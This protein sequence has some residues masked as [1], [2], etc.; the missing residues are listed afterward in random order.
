MGIIRKFT[1][2][3][4]LIAKN[5]IHVIIFGA[6]KTNSIRDLNPKLAKHGSIYW[7]ALGGGNV[8]YIG[9]YL[10][11]IAELEGLVRFVKKA[12]DMPEP[13]VGLTTSPVPAHLWQMKID[14]SLCDLNYKIISSLKDDS[15]KPTSVVAEELGVSTKTVRRR[16]N[17]MA[18]NFLI[19]SPSTGTLM[20]ETI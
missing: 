13:T 19:V 7:L 10:K 4:S 18:K 8:L 6:S 2:K 9:A 14:T 16:L 1:T 5:G 12:A 3:P 17:R 11:H 15:R 20:L